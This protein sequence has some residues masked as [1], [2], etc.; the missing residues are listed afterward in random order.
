VDAPKP[1]ITLRQTPT[2]KPRRD[3]HSVQTEIGKCEKR[4]GDERDS[5]ERGNPHQQVGHIFLPCVLAEN[6][7]PPRRPSAVEPITGRR[8][9]L[10]RGSDVSPLW[11]R[12]SRR[13]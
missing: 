11:K 9:S 13:G 10:G 12:V 2:P 3:R 4:S 6:C 5:A 1:G 8:R 7:P